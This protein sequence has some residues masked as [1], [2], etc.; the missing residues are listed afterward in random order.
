M[1]V[2][3]ATLLLAGGAAVGQG[4]ATA[5]PVIEAPSLAQ[6]AMKIRV[7]LVAAPGD[8]PPAIIGS[9]TAISGATYK[10]YDDTNALVLTGTVATATV[11]PSADRD[12]HE[13]WSHY[14]SAPLNALTPG[15][16][17]VRVNGVSSAYFDVATGAW[18]DVLATLLPV[19]R[20]NADGSE[21]ATP[22]HGPSHLNDATSKIANGPHAN[23]AI[24]VRGG[25]MDA[26]DQLKFTQTIAFATAMLEL[27]GRNEAATRSTLYAKAAI[28]IRFLLKAHPT[29]DIFVTQVGNATIDHNYGFRDPATDDA[30]ATQ[31]ISHRKTYVI[32]GSTT[33]GSDVAAIAAA[34][35][36]LEAE[37]RGGAYRTQLLTAAEEWLAKAEALKKVWINC[38][39]Q[40]DTWR[41]DVAFAHAALWRATGDAAHAQAALAALN[42]ATSGGGDGWRITADGYDMAALPAAELCGVLGAPGAPAA[43]RNPACA[44]LV[45]GGDNSAWEVASRTGFGRAGQPL[46]GAVRNDLASA[47]AMELADREGSQNFTASRRRATGWFLGVNP[48]GVRMQVV[49]RSGAAAVTGGVTGVYHWTTGIGAPRI[50]GAVPGGPDTQAEIDSQREW[51]CAPIVLSSLD[52]PEQVY[53]RDDAEDYVMNEIGLAYNAPGLLLFAL[54]SAG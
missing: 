48:W 15:R 2:L 24:D 19:F 14:Y 47:L 49:G 23:T 35:L 29:S 5:R 16:Y 7:P 28:G 17:Q 11:A 4:P 26:G 41:D 13:V 1:S 10:V 38:C 33:G 32:N 44:I 27:A 12:A 8:V 9:P 20:A 54:L 18:G 37:H 39:Y 22:Y 31:G 42:T 36:A 21:P 52:T 46:W 6:P 51:C 3:A 45:A 25:W 43:I 50:T 40:Q 53:H 30:S 34:A